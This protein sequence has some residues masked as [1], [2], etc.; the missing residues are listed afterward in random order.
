MTSTIK[1]PAL[2]QDT[3]YIRP[4]QAE[5]GGM[6][7]LTHLALL[8]NESGQ[9]VRGYV[10]HYGTHQPRGLLNEW[11]G[12]TLQA[13]LGVPQPSSAILPAPL[14]GTGQTGWAFVSLQ[15]VPTFQGTPKQIYDLMDPHQHQALIKRLLACPALPLLVAADQL[16]ANDDRNMGNLVFTGKTSFVAIDQGSILGGLNWQLADLWFKAQWARAKPIE[17][18]TPI[19]SLSLA[20]KN[21]IYA[22][23]ELV[24]QA[25]FDQQASL[26]A[27]L[28]A[29]NNTEVHTAMQAIWWRALALTQWF[30]NRL[31]LL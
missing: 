24:E 30:K 28:D 16:L 18:L 31:N 2:W 22:A 20:Q 1:L 13:A 5:H 15:P 29:A 9:L 10:K 4:I 19:H 11:L 27:A 7:A 21:A 14:P 12:Y 6:M 26:G 8:R 17:D 23:A 3:Q 25:Y